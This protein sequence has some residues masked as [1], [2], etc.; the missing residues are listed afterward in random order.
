[1]P[2]YGPLRLFMAFQRLFCVPVFP[3]FFMFCNKRQLWVAREAHRDELESRG[4]QDSTTNLSVT[5]IGTNRRFSNFHPQPL[6][7]CASTTSCA[8]SNF[9]VLGHSSSDAQAAAHNHDRRVRLGVGWTSPPAPVV[10]IESATLWFS[11][12]LFCHFMFI[13]WP[14][15]S[16]ACPGNPLHYQAKCPKHNGPTALQVW[17][18]GP[19]K[20]L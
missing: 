1:M 7:S 2:S 17:L 4:E 3:K 10:V 16:T 8:R 19:I 15:P 6:N 11:M 18:G 12:S 13:L 5:L 20:S 9:C 14:C